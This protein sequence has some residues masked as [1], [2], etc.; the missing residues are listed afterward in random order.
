MQRRNRDVLGTGKV[1]EPR[2]SLADIA[3]QQSAWLP[4]MRHERNTRYPLWPSVVR[5]ALGDRQRA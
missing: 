4:T 1:R 2:G 5:R 3:Q